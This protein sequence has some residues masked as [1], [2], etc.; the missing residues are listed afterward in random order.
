[1]QVQSSSVKK[2]ANKKEEKDNLHHPLQT[3]GRDKVG[4][5]TDTLKKMFCL[6]QLLP[7]ILMVSFTYEG[8]EG[9]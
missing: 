1:M 5:V 8:K 9:M 7:F 6:F 2:N 3:F 4:S